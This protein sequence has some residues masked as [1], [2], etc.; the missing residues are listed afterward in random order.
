MRSKSNN[1]IFNKVI[2][3]FIYPAR[4][5]VQPRE[6]FEEKERGALTSGMFLFKER[7]WRFTLV[8]GSSSRAAVNLAQIVWLPFSPLS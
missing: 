5:T 2:P 6:G 3:I 8:P 1:V 7:D 4:R